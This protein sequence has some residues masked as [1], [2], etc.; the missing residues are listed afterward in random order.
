MNYRNGLIPQNG[1]T[2]N[3]SSKRMILYVTTI[4]SEADKVTNQMFKELYLMRPRVK[5]TKLGNMNV[6]KYSFEFSDEFVTKNVWQALQKT[7]FNNHKD[8]CKFLRESMNS[9]YIIN[10]I[11]FY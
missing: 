1:I 2:T 3:E 6:T 8:E 4:G 5:K 9:I 11:E 7:W 10:Q